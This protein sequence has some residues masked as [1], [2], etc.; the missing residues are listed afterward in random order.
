MTIYIMI[1]RTTITTL[2]NQKLLMRI[3][4]CILMTKVTMTNTLTQTA[5]IRN[6]TTTTHTHVESIGLEEIHFLGTTTHQFITMI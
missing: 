1:R 2:T 6:T 5:T 3:H 4:L